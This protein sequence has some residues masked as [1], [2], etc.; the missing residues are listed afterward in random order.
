M[1]NLDS[2]FKSRDITLPTK[3][4]LAKAMVFPVVM[5]GCE[6]WTIKKAERQRIDAFE[7][8]CWRS[9]LTVSWTARLIKPVHP[10]GNQFWIITGRTD[11]EAETL[12]FGHL[13][14]RTDSSELTPMLGKIEGRRR[15]QQRITWLDGITNSMDMSLS[16]LQ[17]LVMDREARHAAVH[18]VTKSQ[19]QLRDWTDELYKRTRSTFEI[20]SIW[21]NSALWPQYSLILR[22]KWKL[23]WSTTFHLPCIYTALSKGETS[24]YMCVLVTQ[25]CLTD[26]LQP[27][28]LSVHWISQAR[29]LEW[30]AIPF[31]RG[32]SDPEIKPGSPVSQT[33]S[34]P[35]HHFSF[36]FWAHCASYTFLTIWILTSITKRKLKYIIC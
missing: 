34:L 20:F 6:S 13:M 32:S 30:V 5:Y 17:E 24:V 36:Q 33:D 21:I 8:W 23:N 2:K 15:G 14:R 28:G 16:K 1:T 9:L 19:T 12:I 35:L 31:S 11:A 4:H 18:R 25:S 27:H 3:V 26:S 29:I 10:K 7:L 22:K